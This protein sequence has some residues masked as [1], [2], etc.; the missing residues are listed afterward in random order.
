VGLVPA[1]KIKSRANLGE[2]FFTELE[3]DGIYAPISYLNGSDNEVVG[4]ILDASLRAGVK[5]D[6]P[7]KAYFNLRYLGGGAVCGSDVDG[8]GDGY[9]RNWLNFLTVTAGFTYEFVY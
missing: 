1:L 6:Q 9:I 7:V 3:A 8:P 4:A 2:R 5:F